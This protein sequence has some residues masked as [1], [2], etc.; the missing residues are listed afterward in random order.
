MPIIIC[1]GHST[2]ISAEDAYA[3]GIKHYMCKPL[4]GDILART[5]RMVLDEAKTNPSGKV[6]SL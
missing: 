4:V 3:M 2:V 6:I 5:V 1:P